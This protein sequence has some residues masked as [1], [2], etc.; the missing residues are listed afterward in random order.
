MSYYIQHCPH[1]PQA[2]YIVL[3]SGLGG[4]ASF[5]KPQIE[6]LNQ[7]FHVLTYDQ[8]GCHA[9]AELLV[10]GYSFQHLASQILEILKQENIQQFHFIGHAIGGFIGAELAI[11]CQKSSA[12]T[13][14]Q[15]ILSLSF[16][17]A[18]DDLDPHTAKCF[19]ARI[20]LLK[21]AG[22]DAYV[23][24]QALF[25]YPPAWI[26]Q[27]HQKIR[28]A[29]DLQL[30]DFPPQH[31]VL[32]R[33]DAARNFKIN[34]SHRSALENVALHFIANKDD[35]LVPVQKSE[36]LKQYL[37]HGELNILDY[38]AHASTITETEKVNQTLIAYYRNQRF[39][40][41]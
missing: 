39:I 10:E 25:L 24:A 7:Y 11:L 4:H 41:Q 30:L 28:Q 23:R 26:S 5:W 31:N 35:F 38:G 8:E 1:H 40:D 3:S 19:E 13:H 9:D 34:Q 32:A 21:K 15:K 6:A 36:D 33:I 14:P 12:S 18:W 37:G 27:Q 17:N 29:E 16:I 2:D 20:H 22:A